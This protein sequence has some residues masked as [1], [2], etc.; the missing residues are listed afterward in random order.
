V[1]IGIDAR[2]LHDFGI[3]TYIRNLLKYL[4]RLDRDT[5]FVLLCKPQDVEALEEIGPN[6]RPVVAPSKP[7]SL[8][9]QFMVPARLLTQ[10]VDLFHEPH[11]VLPLLVPC[12]AVVTIHDCIHLM[13]PQYLPN[14]FA[15]AYARANLW[16]AAR[17]AERILTVSETSK[18]DILRYCDVPADRIIVIYNAIDDHF[19]TPPGDEAVQRVRERYQL[20]GP[21]ALYVGNI[22]PHKNLERLIDAFDLV[23]RGGFERME[24]LIIGDQISKYPRLRRTVDKHKLHKHVRFLGFVPDDTLAALYRLATVFVFPSLYEG[25]GL[26]PL[27]AMASGTPVVTSNRSSLPEI[28]GDAAELVDPYSAVS[29][30]EGIQRVLSDASLR[31]TM[32][33]RGL[34]R[35]REFSWEA[36][37]RRIHEVY[38]DV[39]SN[40]SWTP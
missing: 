20:D 25:F 37:V 28:V 16:T 11:Y 38:M 36:S 7:Y 17:R 35:A 13:F 26:P 9:E 18:A 4:A 34:A 31:Q 23:R 19:A 39:A 32:I 29:I 22:K 33:A 27:E 12:R 10:N 14:R 2:K 15:Y 21:F 5:E 1:R 30:A 24:L 40:R 8:A 3:G 6:F